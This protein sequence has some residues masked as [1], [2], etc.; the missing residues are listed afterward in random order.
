M[1]WLVQNCG[2][3]YNDIIGVGMEM[4]ML[5]ILKFIFSLEFIEVEI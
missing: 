4:D 3:I 5:T 1:L 2:L